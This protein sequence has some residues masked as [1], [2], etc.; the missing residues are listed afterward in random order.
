MLAVITIN[1]GIASQVS[2]FLFQK[3]KIFFS[4]LIF[5]LCFCL[6]DLHHAQFLVIC[7]VHAIGTTAVIVHLY[8]AG[9]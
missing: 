1:K 3:F 5:A 4:F 7:F 8:V 6:N 9:C 2:L